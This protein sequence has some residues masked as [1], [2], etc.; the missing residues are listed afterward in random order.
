[1]TSACDILN[2]L[3]DVLYRNPDISM[4]FITVKFKKNKNKNCSGGGVGLPPLEGMTAH[5]NS[6][7]VNKGCIPTSSHSLLILII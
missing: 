5:T 7:Y 6:Q 4:S 2:I 1:M 3:N